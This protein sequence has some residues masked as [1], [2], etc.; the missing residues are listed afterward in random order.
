VE[1]TNNPLSRTTIAFF[2]VLGLL[3]PVCFVGVVYFISVDVLIAFMPVLLF[4][5]TIIELI[6]I[7]IFSVFYASSKGKSPWI[8]SIIASG[9]LIG[10]LIAVF[11]VDPQYTILGFF[12]APLLSIL[13]IIGLIKILERKKN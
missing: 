8:W 1:N 5:F 3:M 2:I 9:I 7:C 11:T 12:L 4:V 13:L 6:F 10:I